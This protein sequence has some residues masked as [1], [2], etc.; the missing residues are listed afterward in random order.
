VT[1][2]QTHQQ[3]QQQELSLRVADNAHYLSV[4]PF[5]ENLSGTVQRV[6]NAILQFPAPA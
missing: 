5:T 4:K 6:I 1:S 2:H 3:K